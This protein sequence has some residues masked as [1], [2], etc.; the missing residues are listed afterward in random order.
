[1]TFDE[2]KGVTYHTE[3]SMIIPG[4][5]TAIDKTQLFTKGKYDNKKAEKILRRVYEEEEYINR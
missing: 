1:M 5:K 4:S 2:F 3:K